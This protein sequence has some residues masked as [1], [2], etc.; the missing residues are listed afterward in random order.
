[1]SRVEIAVE[2]IKYFLMLSGVFGYI[3]LFL[4]RWKLKNPVN[5]YF[6]IPRYDIYDLEYVIQDK[7]EY[8]TK[9]II[10]PSNKQCLILVWVKPKLNFHENE[11]YIGFEV[12]NGRKDKRKPEII[13]YYNPFV[14]RG[15]EREGDP[16]SN[17]NHYID[18]W[19]C[20][21]IGTNKD[22]IKDEVYVSGYIVQTYDE[23]NY[24]V[25]VEI[26]T[27][28]RKGKSKNLKI[29][30]K[31]KFNEKITCTIPPPKTWKK[32]LKNFFYKERRDVNFRFPSTLAIISSPSSK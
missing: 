28:T 6:L 19:K 12:E 30:V 22:R 15:Q 1:M 25:N 8:L 10:L 29:R 32:K 26:C 7:R 18:W 5:I 16:M 13:K 2:V 11:Q 9:E 3:Y 4:R 23:G 27:P 17:K 20:Y 21:H 31:N 14:L 24:D